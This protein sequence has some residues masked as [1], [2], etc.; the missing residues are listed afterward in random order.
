MPDYKLYYYVSR[1]RGELARLIFNYAG[2]SFEDNRFTGLEW[3]S[4]KPSNYV[5]FLLIKN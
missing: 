5:C 2:V 4:I 3:P 1:G